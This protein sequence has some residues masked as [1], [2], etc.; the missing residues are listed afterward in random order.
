MSEARA[1]ER[2]TGLTA[3]IAG[4]LAITSLWIGLAGL[5]YQ[6]DAFSGAEAIL[7]AGAAA[8]PYIRWSQICNLLGNYLLLFPTA[9][10]LWRWLRPA[11]PPFADFYTLAGLFFL[12]VGG[13]ASGILVGAWPDMLIDYANAAGAERYIIATIFINF[14]RSIENGL[15]GLVQNL[16]GAIWLLG[17]GGMLKRERPTLGW[18]TLIFGSFML[19]NSLGSL[20]DNSTLSMIGFSGNF[21]ILPV[22]AV[23]IGLD[24]LRRP[25]LTSRN[26]NRQ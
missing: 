4:V 26:I 7:G 1:F 14:T 10:L 19:V 16:P 25:A 3:I 20:L 23:W 15:Q 17:M 21:L 5:D 22:W 6:L 18:L 2:M 24:L 9:L 12:S 11:N 8:A 13:I